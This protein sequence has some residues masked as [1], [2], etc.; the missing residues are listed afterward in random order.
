MENMKIAIVD[1][2]N[3][4]MNTLCGYVEQFGKEENA[5]F[6]IIKFC[7]GIDF[8]SEYT[9]DYDII[10]M[11]IRMPLM[12]GMETARRLRTLDES[13]PLIFVTNLEK[14]AVKGYEVNAFDFLVKPVSYYAF[15]TKFARA[16]QSAK[17]H[18]GRELCVKTDVGVAKVNVKD[19]FY[20]E[21]TGRYVT[22]HT[23]QGNLEFKRSMK[24][25]EEILKEDGFVRCDNS[26][27][28]NLSYVTNIDKQSAMVA[29]D[30]VP[31]SR[32]R[33]K[34]FINALTLF[35]GNDFYG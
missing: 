3:E 25:T 8:I 13:V 33:R 18:K 29:G 19:I 21:V 15:K 28:V 26:F 17:K 7:T 27:L 9:A 31:V 10:F 24:D 32:A 11:D 34:F 22:L 5:A 23:K 30:S 1:D 14:Y 35:A 6:S 2:E 12:S 16:V 20:A 4:S